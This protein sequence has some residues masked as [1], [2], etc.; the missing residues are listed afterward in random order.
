[1]Y[2][3]AASKS[4]R[5]NSLKVSLAHLAGGA[6]HQRLDHRP[7]LVIQQVHLVNDQ[8]ADLSSREESCYI[9][10]EKWRQQQQQQPLVDDQQADLSSRQ[11][12]SQ[13]HVRR[14]VRSTQHRACCGL[15]PR[16]KYANASANCCCHQA[17]LY[18]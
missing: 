16:P 11:A 18:C 15:Q 13:V 3:K 14:E 17:Q 12:E 2:S 9:G 6:R 10:T 7:A 4:A 1:M 8:Q 5:H